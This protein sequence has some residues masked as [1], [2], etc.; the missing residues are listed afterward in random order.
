MRG[1]KIGFVSV[2]ELLNLCWLFSLLHYSFR[3][4]TV[5]LCYFV[6]GTLQGA[7]ANS[8]NF[9]GTVK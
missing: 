1:S 9:K 5:T 4:K 7:S 8:D 3:K 2:S 6:R